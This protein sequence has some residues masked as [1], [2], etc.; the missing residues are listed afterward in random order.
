MSDITII[1]L[2]IIQTIVIVTVLV[3]LTF[4]IREQNALYN[5][6]IVKGLRDVVQVQTAKHLSAIRAA[7]LAAIEKIHVTEDQ[8]ETTLTNMLGMA[9]EL[10]VRI[11]QII[12]VD[13]N[14]PLIAVRSGTREYTLSS[15][16]EG[17][18]GTRIVP[19][20]GSLIAAD[21][22]F[23]QCWKIYAKQ[24]GAKVDGIPNQEVWTVYERQLTDHFA[25]STL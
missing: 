11:E 16:D 13:H 24:Q 10:P 14:Y 25:N 9:L 19:A 8:V 1:V 7:R 2:V 12:R 15:R 6:Q 18:G 4:S 3:L 23:F 20:E 21:E 22:V 5:K 17:S